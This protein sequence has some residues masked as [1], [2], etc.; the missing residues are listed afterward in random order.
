M[1]DMT[2]I[3]ALNTVAS[4]SFKSYS[5]ANQR[6]INQVRK[7]TWSSSSGGGGGFSSGSS[8]GGGSR[9]GGGAF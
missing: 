6:S 3:G 8:G 7:S 5:I 4:K 2:S 9:G 1:E